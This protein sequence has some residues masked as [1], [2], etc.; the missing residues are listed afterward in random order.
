MKNRNSNNSE[1]A[2]PITI[3]TGVEAVGA[4]EQ[5]R[6]GGRGEEEENSSTSTSNN[7]RRKKSVP[8]RARG[9]MIQTG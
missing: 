5:G 3:G 1:G 6:R 9:E 4:E 2:T 8:Q 7:N